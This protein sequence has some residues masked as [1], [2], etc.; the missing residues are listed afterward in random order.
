MRGLLLAAFLPKT[1][2]EDMYWRLFADP[3]PHLLDKRVHDL[4]AGGGTTLVEA[5]RLG[6][7]PS[8][9]DV[10]PLAVMIS[11]H[12]L[13]RPEAKQIANAGRALL[14]FLY[15]QT[16][17]L[18]QRESARW[19]PLHYFSLHQV[20]CP[21]CEIE[22]LLHRDLIIARGSAKSGAVVRDYDIIAFCPDCLKV[23]GLHD[24]DRKFLYCCSRSPLDR[25]NY[26]SQ[27][28][29]CQHCGHKAAHR[30]L[31]TGVAPRRLIAVEETAQN[32]HRR[33]RAAT[34]R[35]RELD[36]AGDAYLRQH[37]A[38]L[39]LP[40]SPF[41]SSRR[42]PRPIS[43]GLKQPAQLFTARQL[44]VFGHGF[45]WIRTSEYP[46]STKAALM[47]GLS[48]ALTTNNRLCG[49]A[50][51]YGRLAPL[52]SVRGY[53]LALLA[54]EL[55]PFHP[56]GGRGTL[57]KTIEKV[58]RSSND[59]VR[60]YVW[61]PTR[62]RPIPS[63]MTF[64][65]RIAQPDVRCVSAGDVKLE[66]GIN[67]LLIF[68]PPY[69][70]YIAYSELSEFHRAWLGA[71]DL[72]GVS[73]LPDSADPVGSFGDGLARC[74]RPA[75]ESLAR[76]RPLVFTFHSTSESAWRAIGAALDASELSVTALWPVRNDGHM[77]HHTSPG[78][79]EWD[80]VVVCRRRSEC[81]PKRMDV[82]VASWSRA[83]A[84]LKI[85]KADRASMRLAI[86]MASERAGTPDE[87]SHACR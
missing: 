5:A 67:D 76:N 7:V 55:N 73:L 54:V 52:F 10:D 1:T 33:I 66:R 42:D 8:G 27:R 57:F 2:S 4:F 47:L 56:S 12:E 85:S 70:D 6:A 37:L 11:R 29:N 26:H 82:E 25:G 87:V 22:T 75:L 36:V 21:K 45:R 18:F 59:E 9:T 80:V 44:A 3:Q 77:G 71:A 61:S 20:R 31:E 23:Y 69:F 63:L 64:S 43:F 38:A 16:S 28:F 60:R 49:Y 32:E 39:D 81:R 62:R 40:T 24:P 83:V 19:R 68:D 51:D 30:D 48:N 58:V 86:V 17:A 53:S 74:L 50:T 15:A 34:Q 65:R 84:P 78:N 79:C 72:G 35:D 13:G 46:S 14:T 41:T